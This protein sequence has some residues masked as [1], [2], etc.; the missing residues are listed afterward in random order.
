MNLLRKVVSP[1]VRGD[2]RLNASPDE[3]TPQR[4]M[5]Q[6]PTN[7]DIDSRTSPCHG[8]GNLSP[9]GKLYQVRYFLYER[10]AY[11]WYNVPGT[12]QQKFRRVEHKI[13]RLPRWW[14]GKGTL[15]SPDLAR[16]IMHHHWLANLPPQF[17]NFVHGL[18]DKSR[19]RI[20][21]QGYL[22]VKREGT[23]NRDKMRRFL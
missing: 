1:N 5:K 10:A 21:D 23:G 22:W 20:G 16:D 17:T 11:R 13:C 9:G 14:G 3:H 4:Q 8:A 15:N 6:Y 7:D 19:M 2:V 18:G 12:T